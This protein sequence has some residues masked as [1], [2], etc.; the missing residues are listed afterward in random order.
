[1]A[2]NARVEMESGALVLDPLYPIN[3]TDLSHAYALAEDWENAPRFAKSADSLNVP[4][5]YNDSLLVRCY[6]ELDRLQEAENFVIGLPNKYD[7]F[8]IKALKA[9]IAMAKDENDIAISYLDSL[10][11]QPEKLI[12][13][14]PII[15]K[16][17]LDFGMLDEAVYWLEKAYKNREGLNLLIRLPEN[18][19]TD[20]KLKVAFDKPEYNALFEIRM[21]NL[22]LTNDIP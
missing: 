3:H 2:G 17:Y 8:S 15:T 5:S 1:M 12:G 10:S 14:C 21:K 4:N 6:I 16:L 9:L 22:G 7:S 18:L 13:S 11:I 20:A 19:P